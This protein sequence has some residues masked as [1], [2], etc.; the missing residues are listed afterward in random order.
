MDA[1]VPT[2][3][4]VF[5]AQIPRNRISRSEDT[6]FLEP[7]EFHCHAGTLWSPSPCRVWGPL[8]ALTSWPQRCIFKLSSWGGGRES[9][10]CLGSWPRTGRTWFSSPWRHKMCLPVPSLLSPR[11]EFPFWFWC[12]GLMSRAQRRLHT[13]LSPYISQLQRMQGRGRAHACF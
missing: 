10:T 13:S 6:G 12:H 3:Q 1:V 7:L 8:G 9:T 11:P 5:L 4:S 2:S